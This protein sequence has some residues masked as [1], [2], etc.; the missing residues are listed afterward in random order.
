MKK[1]LNLIKIINFA[2]NKQIYSKI[3][4]MIA[5]NK[6]SVDFGIF[7]LFDEVSFM[8]NDNEKLGL[9]GKNGAGKSTLLKIIYGIDTATSG[10]VEK[11]KDCTLGYLPQQMSHNAGKTVLEEAHSAFTELNKTE[12]EI[13]KIK[14][15]IDSR[16]DYKSNQ[17][18]RLI[19]RLNEL[20]ERQL[21]LGVANKDALVEQTLKGLGY[22][23]EDFHRNTN[24]FSGGWQM[25]IELAKILM[26]KPDVLL[27]DEPTNHLDIEAIQWLEDFLVN[28][29]G[30]VVLISHDRVFLDKITNR[31]IEISLGKIYDYK[32]SYS[33]YVNLRKER[34]QQQLA[35][36]VNQQKK[37]A[38]TEKFIEKF[39]YKASKA[40]QVQSRIKQLEKLDII[41]IDEQD[42]SALNFRFPPAPRSGSVVVETNLLSKS[43]GAKQILVDIDLI[44][45]RQNKVAFV[46]RNGEGK[47]TLSRIIAGDLDYEG[48]LK[49]GHNVK[50]GYY[51]QNQDELLDK[52][53]TVFDTLN[54]IAVGD[55]RMQIRNILGAFLFSGETVDK[56][57]KVLSGGERSRLAL[58][59]LLLEP[60]NLLVLDEPT[61]HLD[62]K[63]KEILKNALKL[64]DGT[65]I[66]VSHDRDFL[67]GLVD[68]IY[69]FANKKIK[70]HSGNIYEFLNKKR[71]SNLKDIEIKKAV[72]IDK[73]KGKVSQNKIDYLQRK[74]RERSRRKIVNRINNIEKKIENIEDEINNLE[75]KMN[76]GKQDNQ[77]FENYDNLKKQLEVNMQNWENLHNELENFDAM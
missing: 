35:E 49:I 11:P 50:I 18:N 36:Y 44:I 28:Y 45:E 71:L 24:E 31:T 62:I 55:V 66:L 60:Y 16:T 12:D 23:S 61:N 74:E 3:I 26:R 6:L 10:S 73:N 15:E 57:V 8:I 33:K 41:E 30:A 43:Y 1:K 13:S 67:D 25:R 72:T 32:V 56:K 52:E 19:N 47:T 68:N 20:N 59:K 21:I 70:Q 63:S 22:K 48:K 53:K 14:L 29:K 64:Y 46:G 37:I 42:N 69:E 51:A 54:D 39:R 76:L 65:L 7:T 77:L 27:L 75:N 2:K 9:V 5:I 38:D 58:A 4:L 40:V 34:Y 17:Y